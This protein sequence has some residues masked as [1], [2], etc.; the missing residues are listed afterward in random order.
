M[1]SSSRV[2]NHTTDYHKSSCLPLRVVNLVALKVDRM[3][4]VKRG[5]RSSGSV[6]KHKTDY[7]KSSYIPVMLVVCLVVLTVDLLVVLWD[8]LIEQ[9]MDIVSC[10]TR[11]KSTRTSFVDHHPGAV[12]LT[13]RRRTL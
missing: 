4:A 2:R 7:H 13:M 6:R 5:G 11:G 3:A 9:T 8:S 12:S 1:R 10:T